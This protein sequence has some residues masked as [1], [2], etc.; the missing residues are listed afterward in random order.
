M[1]SKE[2]KLKGP[3]LASRQTAAAVR[4]RVLDQAGKGIAVDVDLEGVASVSES[5]ADELF[6]VLVAVKG[7]DWLVRNVKVAHASEHVLRTIAVAIDRRIK[8]NKRGVALS[9]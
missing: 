1:D 6:G 7:L 5:Y 2:I 3:D 8:S 4:C 9:A